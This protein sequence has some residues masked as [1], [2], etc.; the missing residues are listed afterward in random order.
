MP[1]GMRMFTSD[2]SEAETCLNGLRCVARL[3]FER[4]GLDRALVR[5]KTSAA[6]AARDADVAPGVVTIRE[7]AGPADLD[8][9]RW[10]L[11]VEAHEIVQQPIAWLPTSRS[12]TAVAMPNPHSVSFVD[13]VDE[14]ELVAVGE[15]CEAAPRLAAEPRQ[16]VL[17]RGARRRAV[18]PHVRTRRRPDRQLRQRDGRLDLRRLPDRPRRVRQRN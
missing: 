9:T 3:G 17:C 4:Q 11:G 16:C 8:V 13:T 2:G 12:F 1:F 6:E 15:V 18:R 14:A 5:L 7:T 10:P